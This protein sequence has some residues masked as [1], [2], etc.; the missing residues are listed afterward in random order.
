MVVVSGN[1]HA[2]IT[3]PVT[4]AVRY[5]ERKLI[6]SITLNRTRAAWNCFG[7]NKTGSPFVPTVTAGT[8]RA[9]SMDRSYGA[10]ITTGSLCETITRG[11]GRGQR[12]WVIKNIVIAM[13]TTCLNKITNLFRDE[14][15]TGFERDPINSMC[16]SFMRHT[17]YGRPYI[18]KR[19]PHP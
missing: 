16:C 6:P 1:A 14:E 19:F 15:S 2:V 17:G 3:W 9:Q 5:A 8:S 7:I 11:T 10:Q 12:V 13:S 18:Q 4:R